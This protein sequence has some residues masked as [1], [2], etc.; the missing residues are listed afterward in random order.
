MANYYST[1]RTNY[2]N[3]KDEDS[4]RAFA[5]QFSSLEI[6]QNKAKQ[7]AILFDQECGVPSWYYDQN[8]EE[9]E[10]DFI[11]EL[12]K[13]L[14]DDSVAIIISVGNEKMRYIDG[15]AEAVNNKGESVSLRLWDIYEMA[16]KLGKDVSRAEY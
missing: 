2:F 8:G 3:V 1:A 7:F 12:A 6:V 9:I 15:Y 13:H 14:A 5:S 10:T 11:Q 4:F 16:A